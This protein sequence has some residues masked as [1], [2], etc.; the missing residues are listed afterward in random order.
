MPLEELRPTN[1]Y[2]TYDQLQ[3]FLA[4][5]LE[6]LEREIE[7][8]LLQLKE[9]KFNYLEEKLNLKTE[10]EA[11][12]EQF[13]ILNSEFI[14]RITNLSY[15]VLEINNF[16][17]Q[18]LVEINQQF[19]ELNTSLISEFERY[20]KD[21]YEFLSKN[22]LRTFFENNADLIPYLLSPMMGELNEFKNKLSAIETN[23]QLVQNFYT[24]I[25]NEI[26]KQISEIIK[27]TIDNVDSKV[28][29]IVESMK[30][31]FFEKI[32]SLEIN[33]N[34][35]IVGLTEFKNEIS[36]LLHSI[37]QDIVEIKNIYQNVQS[38]EP[39]LPQIDFSQILSEIKNK[40][41]E[42]K[43]SQEFS[44]EFIVPEIPDV[45]FLKVFSQEVQNNLNLLKKISEDIAINTS[46]LTLTSPAN[47]DENLKS[48]D[49]QLKEIKNVFDEV[50]TSQYEVQN[51]MGN[52]LEK[53]TVLTAEI[54]NI[55]KS[56]KKD[57]TE[58]LGILKAEISKE[59]K[60]QKQDIISAVNSVNESIQSLKGYPAIIIF[61][62]LLI[63][64]AM[65][66]L[67]FVF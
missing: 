12:K 4:D 49:V 61:C 32:N 65:I 20:R 18:K 53:V 62:T 44:R 36:Q 41:E 10:L 22:D 43:T 51:N 39:A 59:L 67:K 35:D 21:F 47:L 11:L 24:N 19:T 34:T 57:I 60:T 54:L 58:N 56:F 29:S 64:G 17:T 25:S 38:S 6:A 23:L 46:S 48:I 31:S 7:A 1:N 13:R 63:I 2:V 55:S 16:F 28:L 27:S 14:T 45:E 52:L 66:L 15:K 42:L 30:E 26:N 40:I 37:N 50:A 3:R 33:G 5:R 8:K 9:S